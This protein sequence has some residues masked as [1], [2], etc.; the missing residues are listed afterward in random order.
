[1][2]VR[3]WWVLLVAVWIS[4]VQADEA[5]DL[6]HIH[7]EAIGGLERLHE[8]TSLKVSGYVNIDARHLTFTFIAQRPNRLRMET[9]AADHVIIQATDGVNPP[10]QMNPEAVP[11]KPVLLQ[12]K[13]A[14]DFSADAEFDDPLVESAS[15]GYTVDYS[16]ETTWDGKP[17]YR[18]LITR[19]FVDSY[20]LILDQKTFFIVGRESTRKREF[21]PDVKIE[22]S[23]EDFRPVAG[24]IMPHRI[25][26]K[27][28]NRLLHETVLERVIPNVPVPT[29]SFT[30]PE[31]G[32]STPAQAH[33]P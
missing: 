28:D 21:G 8:L 14:R 30:M 5:E 22:T 13:E 25:L 23:Y 26:V 19:R 2:Y 1:M 20:Y 16:G 6:A 29:G 27:A 10:W 24:V 15:K 18:L 33:M 9:R 7:V 11:L 3:W 17:A 31:P 4:P 32:S 12:G